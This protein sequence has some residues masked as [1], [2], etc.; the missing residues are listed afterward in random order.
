MKVAMD[1]SAVTIDDLTCVLVWRARENYRRALRHAIVG[2]LTLVL[3]LTLDRPE[4]VHFMSRVASMGLAKP[5]ISWIQPT[6]WILVCGMS[7]FSLLAFVMAVV[8]R[9]HVREAQIL[10][11]DSK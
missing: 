4:V 10:V 6:K 11:G 8:S 5:D 2:L 7:I 9:K 3:M 1:N